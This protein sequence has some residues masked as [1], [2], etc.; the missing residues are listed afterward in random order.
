MG[1]EIIG[2]LT[3]KNNGDFKLVD[4][5]D[6]DYDGTGKS[7]KEALDEKSTTA[8]DD[9]STAATDKTL[10]VKKIHALIEQCVQKEGGKK[11]SSNDYTTAEKEKLSA[12]ENYDDTEIKNNIQ[13]QKARIDSFTSLKEGST[14]GDAELK[15]GRVG[16][17]GTVYNNIGSA[18][19]NQNKKI[20][21]NLINTATPNYTNYFDFKNIRLEW[22]EGYY[23]SASANAFV[24][25]ASKKCNK[26]K[27]SMKMGEYYVYAQSISEFICFKNDTFVKVITPSK[28]KLV[29]D[30]NYEVI[31]NYDSLTTQLLVLPNQDKISIVQGYNAD[32]IVSIKKFDEID[33]I[34]SKIKWCTGHY[35]EHPTMTYLFEPRFVCNVEPIKFNEPYILIP[36]KGQLI[37]V[38]MVQDGFFKGDTLQWSN[39]PMYLSN[40]D[41][42]KYHIN[43]K[44]E[45]NLYIEDTNDF[46]DLLTFKQMPL[47]HG[48][49][50]LSGAGMYDNNTI[51]ATLGYGISY[52]TRLIS[53]FTVATEDTF[54][55]CDNPLIDFNIVYE[56]KT[57]TGFLNQTTYKIINNKK[58]CLM[59]RYKDTTKSLWSPYDEVLSGLIV[60]KQNYNSIVNINDRPI[61]TY[62][63][64][65]YFN[66]IDVKKQ[67]LNNSVNLTEADTY[68]HAS[69]M[70]IKNNIAYVVNIANTETKAEFDENVFVRL[71]VFNINTP[72]ERTNYEVAK[73]GVYGDIE[74]QG[75]CSCVGI[76][77]NGDNM[78][79]V[80]Y[81]K[82]NNEVTELHRSFNTKTSTFG[83]IGICK[84]KFNNDTYNLTSTNIDNIIG[85]KNS[86][87]PVGFEMAMESFSF[88]NGY[89]YTWFCSGAPDEYNGILF[90][91]N[92][93]INYEF[94]LTPN[95][96]T[97]AH[98][99][100]M[101][102]V[103][104]GYLYTAC[105]RHYNDNSLLLLKYNLSN[106]KLEDEVV[107]TD[108]ASRP[109]FYEHNNEIYLVHST[110]V[111]N[112]TSIVKINKT[113]L[114]E[115]IPVASIED[116]P[117]SYFSPFVV[118]DNVYVSF[119]F[120]GSKYG[121]I[122][123]SH[124]NA[125]MRFSNS[126]IADKLFNIMNT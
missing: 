68:A 33:T 45:D 117:F 58:Y 101:A 104:D 94:V 17:D 126:E 2:K 53:D 6:V 11:L 59:L 85:V 109:H 8:I 89:W 49:T 13:V 5:D 91:T 37:K 69:S 114:I 14:T 42:I 119:S 28:N 93:F 92:D 113:R 98:C 40:A 55:S 82:V 111:R 15:D 99:E 72:N 26:R 27:V 116:F 108:C 74:L 20:D 31:C 125:N 123:F 61:V 32:N 50:W 79:I 18:I 35:Y 39:K 65:P 100:I 12:L 19:R 9:N 25:N 46:V 84:F 24:E 122:C 102:Y 76:A 48:Y 105:R 110:Y 96:R 88:Y 43:I 51:N 90:K 54:I 75:V 70:V 121:A 78:E 73:K 81:S 118:N 22:S 115:S 47:F 64:S 107:F 44:R 3:Q 10:S 97:K 80:F 120:I 29:L 106:N 7:A 83:N 1:I 23:F 56:D 62:I 30:D 95:F 112:N 103:K 16:E 67:L 87:L 63:L 71:T 66:G 4:L 52:G 36:G 38:M 86:I 60:K 124:Y 21:N 41:G 34:K 77:E 57:S